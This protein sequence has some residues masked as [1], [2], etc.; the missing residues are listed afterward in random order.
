MAEVSPLRRRMI[1]DMTI[2]NLSPAT[3]QESMQGC[4][5]CSDLGKFRAHGTRVAGGEDL[6]SVSGPGEP[7]KGSKARAAALD[8]PRAQP[9]E[10]AWSVFAAS[11]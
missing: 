5:V 11:S 2:R 4:G 6:M 8:P 7:R 9:L 3:Q 1:E 10:P